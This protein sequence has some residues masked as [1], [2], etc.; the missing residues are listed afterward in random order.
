MSEQTVLV[1]GGAGYIGSH[2]C[3]AL[4][5]AGLVPVTYDNL[6]NGHEWAVRWGPLERGDTRDKARL[7]EVLRKH[8]PVA[9]M[10]FAALI[11]AG[12]SVERPGLY[13]DNNVSGTLSVL[14]AMI[15]EG[16]D[17]ILFSSTAAVYGEPEQVPIPES[18]RLAPIN[19]YGHSKR[20]VE[21]MLADFARAEGLRSVALRYFNAAGAD[22]DGEIG[23]AHDPETHL[24][25]LTLAAAR[26]GTPVK[27]FGDRYD[28]RDGTCIRDYI[29]V[30][31]L[32]DAHMLALQALETMEGFQVFNLGNGEGYSVLEIIAAAR[33]VTG[34]EIAT[35]I[36][37]PRPGDSPVLVADAQ[38]A[39][40]TLGWRPQLTGISEQIAHAW[41]WLNRKDRTA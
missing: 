19:P 17:R 20:F 6:S 7:T 29:H 32:V 5:R 3:K 9:V 15:A 25:P 27:V 35:E 11:A 39:I 8:K 13:Y 26:A 12:E 30:T 41:T 33:Q 10:H 31:D 34:L 23:E 38:Q 2:A 18:H 16:V 22:P 36:S 24:I 21:Q 1:T 14:E 4:A 28:T 37:P 40:R